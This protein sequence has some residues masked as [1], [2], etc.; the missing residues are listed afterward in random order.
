M[1]RQLF[2]LDTKFVQPGFKY[3]YDILAGAGYY[4]PSIMHLKWVNGYERKYNMI[5]SPFNLIKYDIMEI[6]KKVEYERSMQGQ[7]D[8]LE[9]DA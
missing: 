2:T 3:K 4:D 5:A 6:N 9:D 8:D 1:V 7:D